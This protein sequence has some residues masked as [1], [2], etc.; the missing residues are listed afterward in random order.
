MHIIAYFEDFDLINAYFGD[1]DEKYACNIQ[2]LGK[3]QLKVTKKLL[4]KFQTK[5]YFV[6]QVLI[7]KNVLYFKT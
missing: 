4:K 5:Y 2:F 3:L 1:F 7:K 6:V